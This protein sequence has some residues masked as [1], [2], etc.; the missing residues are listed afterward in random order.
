MGQD[1]RDVRR[2]ALSKTLTISS[3]T[4]A[5][6]SKHRSCGRHTVSSFST[7]LFY[8]FIFIYLGSWGLIPGSHA[9]RVS[10]LLPS[11]ARRLLCLC[12][13]KRDPQISLSRAS[14]FPLTLKSVG[15]GSNLSFAT[16]GF[17]DKETCCLS[18][19]CLDFPSCKWRA[20]M[21]F[22]QGTL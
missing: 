8:L 9:C 13:L 17:C 6:T 19:L 3:S 22:S 16:S 7:V 5:D 12:P 20:R 15:L 18:T 21:T 1:L 10:T 11:C 4:K 14:S 2:T